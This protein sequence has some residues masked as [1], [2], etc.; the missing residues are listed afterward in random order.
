MK[1]QLS[2]VFL[3]SKG[4]TQYPALEIFE[5]TFAA[6]KRKLVWLFSILKSYIS[7]LL[8][9]PFLLFYRNSIIYIYDYFYMICLI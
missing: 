4:Y 5:E 3:L 6:S 9:L 8:F 1:V 7:N 2:V